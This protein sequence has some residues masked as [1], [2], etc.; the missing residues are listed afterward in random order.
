MYTRIMKEWLPLHHA[1]HWKDVSCSWNSMKSVMFP[2]LLG[3]FSSESGFAFSPWVTVPGFE[4]HNDY[5]CSLVLLHVCWHYQFY[6]PWLYTNINTV[7]KASHKEFWH[8]GSPR[9]AQGNSEV[10]GPCFRTCYPKIC[11][12]SISLFWVKDT[13]NNSNRCRKGP[14]TFLKAGVKTPMWKV[15]SLHLEEER[16]SDHQ[17]WGA[18]VPDRHLHKQTL[19]NSSSCS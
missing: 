1:E 11:H 12:S 10:W 3:K 19:L 7:E 14:L 2:A 4:E 6:P 5:Q 18:K 13:Y 17:R 8:P 16:Y 15:S 9:R